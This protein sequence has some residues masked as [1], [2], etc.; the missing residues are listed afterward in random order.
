M[1]TF[2]LASASIIIA[3]AQAQYYGNTGGGVN[4][5]AYFEQSGKHAITE[6]QHKK[7]FEA[8]DLNKDGF[9]DAQEVRE[10]AGVIN[11]NAVSVFFIESD[12]DEDGK[13]SFEE[14]MHTQYANHDVLV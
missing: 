7:D 6:K 14:Y 3:T 13:V 8:F 4:A 1:K 5:E 9:V 10:K 12:K 2:F 11:Q